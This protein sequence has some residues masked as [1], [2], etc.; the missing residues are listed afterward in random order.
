MDACTTKLAEVPRI[1]IDI[2]LTSYSSCQW[3][4]HYFVDRSNCLV[5]FHIVLPQSLDP[6]AIMSVSWGSACSAQ[7]RAA[8][9][10]ALFIILQPLFLRFSKHTVSQYSFPTPVFPTPPLCQPVNICPTF[11]LFCINSSLSSA[12]ISLSSSRLCPLD[13]VRLA[14]R[15]SMIDFLL[16]I[17]SLCSSHF[18]FPPYPLFPSSIWEDRPSISSSR[19]SPLLLS[20]T[21]FLNFNHCFCWKQ[22]IF[23]TTIQQTVQGNQKP[24]TLCHSWTIITKS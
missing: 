19:W 1:V 24:W 2:I 8:S 10:S 21:S 6:S 15:F 7:L 13:C 22:L 23:K 17:M 5:A 3:D 14:I 12:S 4:C 18:H 16:S 11:S 20:T 9:V